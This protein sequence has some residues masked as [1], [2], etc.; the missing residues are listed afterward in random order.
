MSAVDRNIR[1]EIVRRLVAEF[2]PEQIVL[3]GSQAWGEPDEHSDLD[4]MVIVSKSD[5]P[6]LQR[7]RRARRCLRGVGVPLDIL[8]KTRDEFDYFRPVVASLEHRV[9]EEGEVLYG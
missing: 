4:L 7:A 5:E 3:F 8:V 1:D 2:D 9:A 6:P